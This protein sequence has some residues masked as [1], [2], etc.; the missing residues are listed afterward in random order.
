MSQ[1]SGSLRFPVST[2]PVDV[3]GDIRNLAEDVDAR[4]APVAS[5]NLTGIP[6]APT[7]EKDTSTTQIATTA[8]VIGQASTVTPATV[9]TPTAGTS[10]RFAR[11]D[12]SHALPT[13]AYLTSSSLSNDAPASTGSTSSSGTGTSV[14]RS[15]HTHATGAH[16][17]THAIGGT[18][19]LSPSDI[20][21]VAVSLLTG[22][23]GDL[24]T[25]SAAS[26]PVRL[27]VGSNG[28]TL[29]ADSTQAAGMR[30]G[31]L[32]STAVPTV[33]IFAKTASYTLVLTDAGGLIEMGSASAQTLT[34][35]TEASV[36]FP[37]GTKIDVL[38][39]GAGQVTIAGASG[40][41]VNATPGLKIS[42]QWGA[43][44]LVKR[45]ANTWVAVGNLS[46]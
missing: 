37:V 7:A 18:D 26:T 12:H 29:V 25:N 17:S 27:A 35:P 36:A 14:S 20:G 33:D 21:A 23:K 5:P 3:P 19:A 42:A 40:V 41:T 2:D 9:G 44:S 46:A 45:A 15:D 43:V 11:A 1:T 16:K 32:T 13:G 8:F 34:V 10:T 22:T 38:Q 31:T 24:I 6:R 30:W 28:R 4:K 39:T